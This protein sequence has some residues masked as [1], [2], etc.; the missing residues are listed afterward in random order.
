[1]KSAISQTL[2]NKVLHAQKMAYAP[3]SRYQVGAVVVLSNGKEYAGCNIENAS[4]TVG[5]CAERTA[6]AK[7]VSEE[8]SGVKITNVVIATHSSPP[9]APCG[10]CRQMINEFASPDCIVTLI[11]PSGEERVFSHQ[12]LLPHSFGPENLPK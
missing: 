5:L 8:G 4:F 12:E 9:A 7:A 3:Y 6:L 10:I 1:M 2:K 11:N